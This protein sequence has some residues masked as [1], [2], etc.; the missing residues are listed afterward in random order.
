MLNEEFERRRMI[1]EED[2]RRRRAL[3]EEVFGTLVAD[4]R[5][6]E[7]LSTSKPSGTRAGERISLSDWLLA[8]FLFVVIALGAIGFCVMLVDLAHDLEV[9]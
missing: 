6:G 7:V 2:L 1:E 8:V 5:T 3:R 9:I 4:S